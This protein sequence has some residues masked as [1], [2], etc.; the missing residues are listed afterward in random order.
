MFRFR[1]RLTPKLLKDAFKSTRMILGLCAALITVAGIL[2]IYNAAAVD[3]SW[4]SAIVIFF[5][6]LIEDLLLFR[7][8]LSPNKSISTSVL[9]QGEGTLSDI[10]FDGNCIRIEMNKEGQYT[11]SECMTYDCIYRVCELR[12]Y[13]IVYLSST[14]CHILSK[15][16]IIEGDL[17]AFNIFLMNKLEKRFTQQ[18]KH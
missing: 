11:S 17:E 14:L 18:S 2:S 1:C 16:S 9:W 7:A 15:D 4:Y 6:C 10:T 5:F 12:D 3:G 13:Y 8:M